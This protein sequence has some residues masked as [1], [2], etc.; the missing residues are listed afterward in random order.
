M[1][2]RPRRREIAKETRRNAAELS[3][4]T[5]QTI[6]QGVEHGAGDFSA[7]GGAELNVFLVA[8]VEMVAAGFEQAEAVGEFCEFFDEGGVVVAVDDFESIERVVYEIFDDALQLRII[9]G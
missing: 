3:L 9:F 2:K 7:A 1:R 5:G 6:A 4:R 8:A